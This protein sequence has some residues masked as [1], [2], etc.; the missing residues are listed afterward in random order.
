MKPDL[1]IQRRSFFR[2]IFAGALTVAGGT[3][4]VR[5]AH[6]A[7]APPVPEKPLISPHPLAVRRR[8]PGEETHD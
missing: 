1:P 4:M 5:T 2:R 6:A 7:L 3:L 8:R